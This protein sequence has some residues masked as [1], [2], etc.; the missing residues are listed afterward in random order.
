MKMKWN[1]EYLYPTI[2]DWENDYEKLE[3]MTNEMINFQGKLGNYEDFL[4]YTIL[5]KELSELH[6]KV[7]IYASLLSD[8]NRKNTDNV[9]RV[10]KMGFFYGKLTQAT[11]FVNP[12]L[13][14][15]G[16]EKIDSFINKSE[17]LAEYRFLVE[18]LF[19]NQEHI[20][21]EK[22]ESL[23][24]NFTQL[25]SQGKSLYSSLAVADKIDK[26]VVLSNGEKIV[27]TSGNYN[28]YLA[29]LESQEDRKA[30]FEA[31]YKQY[32]DHKNI[33][34]QIYNTV[35]QRDIAVIKTRNYKSS[36]ESYLYSNNIPMEVYSNLIEV[37]KD[38][39]EPIKRYYKI[40]KEYLGLEKHHTYDS[41]VSLAEST[42]KF[43]YDEA[44]NLFFDSIKGFSK[45]FQDKAHSAIEDGFVD[46]FEKEGKQTGAYSWG[47]INQHPYIL[48]NFDNTLHSVFTLAHEAGHAMHSLF[49]AESQPVATQS[50]TIF[51]AEIAS[52][53]NEHNL[54]DHFINN[55]K[56]TKEDKITLL[57][58]SIDD[59]IGT[60]YSQTLLAA[61]ELKAHEMAENGEAI[62]YES[63]S[64]IMIDLYKEFYGINITEETGKE[65]VWAYVPHLYYTPFYVYQYATSFAASLKL[66]E[67][68]KED[69][70]NIEKHINLLKSGGNDFPVNQVKKAGIDLTTKETFMAVVNRL[71]NLLD[72]LEVAL[73]E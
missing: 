69:P 33:Y 35:L 10:Q 66:Y 63:L 55:A 31:Y 67:M 72:E 36:L 24:A 51:V 6:I 53:F 73:K 61:Y 28:S 4:A 42:S 64:S 30:V 13:L 65:F 38:N 27:I 14:S 2:K 44:R 25:S 56:A 26:E 58:Q 18:K 15:V 29:D 70:K 12:E 21:D 19:R 49:A 9:A 68:V 43:T 39:T 3:E 54:L 8:L 20:L 23:L 62:T 40:R 11:A 5:Q 46:V 50:Y 7:H 48:L 41:L 59:I 57:Q 17:E 45:D 37:A 60:F 52:T 22:S 71:N 16:K 47:A 1:L 32:A 34:A